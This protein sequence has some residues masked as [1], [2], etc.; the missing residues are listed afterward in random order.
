M[1][2]HT[3]DHMRRF[4]WFTK[5]ADD[6]CIEWQG[7]L[8]KKGYGWFQHKGKNNMAHRI[9]YMWANNLEEIPDG[10]CVCHTCD[11]PKCV[12]PEHLWIGTIQD[13]NADAR[14]KGRA[15]IFS[16]HKS[17]QLQYHG[18]SNLTNEQVLQIRKMGEDGMSGTEIAEHFPVGR[19]HIYR[20][21]GGKS[22][23]N[24]K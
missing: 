17:F 6:G 21:L 18:S 12:N 10:M 19:D 15:K 20:I 2:K 14:N 22:W 16:G 9:S 7:A 11:N 23:V 13:N 1:T 5:M 4:F 8:H 24:L 3:L